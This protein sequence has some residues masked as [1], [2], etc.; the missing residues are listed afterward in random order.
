M[1]GYSQ[2]SEELARS[3]AMKAARNLRKSGKIVVRDAITGRYLV[4]EKSTGRDSR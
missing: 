1:S 3:I 2:R 4:K